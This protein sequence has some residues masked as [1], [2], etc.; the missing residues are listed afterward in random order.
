MKIQVL[1]NILKNKLSFVNHAV[2]SK[3]QLPILLNI[4]IRAQGKELKITATDLEIGIETKIP[5]KIEEEGEITIPAR[6]F[7]ELVSSLNEETI[8]IETKNKTSLTVSTKKTKST[9]QTIN[10]EEFP[11]IYK[12]KGEKITNFNKEEGQKDFSQVIFSASTDTTRPALSGVLL[13]PEEEG[14]LLVATDGYRLSL[15]HHK[16]KTK[17]LNNKTP[18]IVPARV[19]KELLSIN[20]DSEEVGM[21]VSTDNNQLLFE[22]GESVLVGRLI[23]A[24]Y[25]NFEKIIP[26]DFSLNVSFDREEMQ[27]AVKTCSVFA[28]D[29]ANIIK[30]SFGKN[31]ITISS[32]STSTGENEVEVE[33]NMKGEDNEIAFNARYLQEALSTINSK[34]LVFEMTGPLNPG[35]FK[36]KDDPS[37]L[38]IIMPVKVQQN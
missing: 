3:G 19:F 35:V 2:S 37:F 29:G 31:K 24:T 23:E 27:R 8:T 17:K 26:T 5:A 36:I 11:N 21:Y 12:E 20:D 14:F 10:E 30:L 9:F 33:A 15:K 13:R 22:Q 1:T 16:T 32:Q 34:E 28:R 18:F 4:L 38:H 25:P 6:T 7:I